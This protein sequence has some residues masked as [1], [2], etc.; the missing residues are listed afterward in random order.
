MKKSLLL[1][2]VAIL[3]IGA[4]GLAIRG[5]SDPRPNVQNPVELGKSVEAFSLPDPTGKATLVGDWDKS[6]ATVLIFVATQ[7]PVSLA[8]DARMAKLATDYAPKGIKVVGINSN[9]QEDGAEVAQ[10]Q[11]DKKLGF[12]VLKDPQNKIADKFDAHVTPEVYVVGA[13][14]KLVYHGAFDNSRNEGEVKTKY[15]A[16]ALDEIVA[17]KAVS[18]SETKAFGCSIKRVD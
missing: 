9:K 10:H 17:G 5:Q 11:A 14:G 12:E 13:D 4:S 2:S 15:L 1:A 16:T 8:Y 6:K 7:C 18:K 3:G